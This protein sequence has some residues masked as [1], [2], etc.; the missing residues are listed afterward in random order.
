MSVQDSGFDVGIESPTPIQIVVKSGAGSVEGV[1]QAGAIVAM[2]PASR[3]ENHA[4]YYGATADALGAFAIRGVAP[5]EYK[6]F[7]WES[8]PGGAY[9]NADFLKKYEDSGRAVTVT[10]DSKLKFDP[11]VIK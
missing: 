3:R 5:G 10:P 7:A 1:A 8:T 9:L 6:I 11:A 4:L 2:I